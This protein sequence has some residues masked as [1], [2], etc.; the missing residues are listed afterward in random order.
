MELKNIGSTFSSKTDALLSEIIQ[1]NN[2]NEDETTLLLTAITMFFSR[3]EISEKEM[4]DLIQKEVNIPP[5]AAEQIAKEIREKLIPTLWDKMP[6]E[7]RDALLNKKIETNNNLN[8]S[9]EKTDFD[10]FP[11]VKP[12]EK[13]NEPEIPA[14]T[15]KTKPKPRGRSRLPKKNLE[16]IKSPAQQRTGPDSYR[17]PIE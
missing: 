7:E 13:V 9:E 15:P 14:P 2:L 17:E 16:E 3:Q 1:K 8:K 4:V 11:K 10:I 6:K 5:Q 12:M